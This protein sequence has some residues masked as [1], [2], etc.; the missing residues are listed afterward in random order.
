MAEQLSLAPDT[1]RWAR[2]R[3]SLDE[4][5]LAGRLRL[6]PEEVRTWETTGAITLALLE[7]LANKTKTPI[8]FLFLDEPPE[9]RLPIEDFRT[10]EGSPP[11]TPSAELLDT[12]ND[13]QRRQDW[14][15]EHQVSLGEDPLPFVGR[16]ARSYVFEAV[17]GDIVQTVGL[18]VEDRARA[19]DSGDALGR[20]VEK[21]EEAG[22]LVMRNGV[23]GNNT[24]RKLDTGEFRGFTLSDPYA[25]LIFVNNTDAK[26]DQIF[27]LAHELAHVWLGQSGISDVA[28][29]AFRS[30][31]RF[32]NQVA[33]EVTVPRSDLREHWDTTADA[34]GLIGRLARR[35]RVSRA[36]VLIRARDIGLVSA[37]RFGPL[38]DTV[39]RPSSQEE[40]SASGGN[41]YTTQNSRLGRRFPRAVIMSALEGQT[42]YRDAMSLVGTPKTET[43]KKYAETLGVP[44]R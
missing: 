41:F 12:V 37:E 27:T 24:R 35:Y 9:E 8:G 11:A 2:L 36:V 26:T 21:V 43:F 30:V 44:F 16:G 42:L 33:G 1:L 39:S 5:A 13:C 22:I 19:R 40:E 15:R 31:E 6:K 7:K 29:S 34:L 23:V 10:V 14:Y 28:N 32:C 25:P 4:D 38:F 17:A 3:A 20:M 18:F